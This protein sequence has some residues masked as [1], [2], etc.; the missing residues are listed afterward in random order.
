MNGKKTYLS[1]L[2]DFIAVQPVI[3]TISV[4]NNEPAVGS[5]VNITARI[6]N[7]TTTGVFLAYRNIYNTPFARIQMADDGLHGDGAAGDGVYGYTITITSGRT[8]Y[9]LYAENSQAGIFSPQRAEMDFYTIN[10]K[11]LDN[12]DIVI[13][14]FMASNS[15]TMAD[16]IGEY[17]DWIELY[18]CT[19][20]II[21]LG[22]L[23]L[24]DSYS[25]LYK[26]KF[27]DNTVI[28][29]QSYLV[30]WADE[31]GS[32]AGLHAN[33]KLSATGERIALASEVAGII[34][35]YSFGEQTTD[36]SMQRCPDGT[37]EFIFA[38]PTYNG[39]NCIPT[40]LDHKTGNM[41][42]TIYPNPFSNKLYVNSCNETIKTIRIINIMGHTIF[43]GKGYN[44]DNL[45]I[46][47]DQLPKGLYMVIINDVICRKV[48]KE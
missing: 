45:E 8:E 36:I 43:Q 6:T 23:Y 33:F 22:D 1:G 41:E 5:Q 32:Q 11:P 47:L 35:S 20:G 18:N 16:Q 31:N 7:A 19:N 3:S 25:N 26:W 27:P 10:S 38:S 12:R 15:S 14:E 29:P 13:N 2:A 48:I 37:G 42:L 9:Y 30:I 34:D 17:D 40:L 46:Y 4:S 21:A 44:N 39:A 24:S 28:L